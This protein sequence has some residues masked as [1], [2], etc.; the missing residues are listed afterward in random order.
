[1]RTELLLNHT[2]SFTDACVG[3]SESETADCRC[4]WNLWA[5][6]LLK[7]DGNKIKR[8]LLFSYLQSVTAESQMRCWWWGLAQTTEERK[9][10]NTK[11]IT[12]VVSEHLIAEKLSVTAGW[13]PLV[14]KSDL[15][16]RFLVHIKV[17][18]IWLIY[19]CGDAS[20]IST[21]C[22]SSIR[23]RLSDGGWCYRRLPPHRAPSK[24]ETPLDFTCSE[25]QLSHHLKQIRFE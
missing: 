20:L 11:I 4:V 7:M 1:M 23:W 10:K 25:F 5:S 21:L 15:A 3:G 9:S 17:A 12:T 24:T 22:I 13:L 2:C 19:D 6:D 16:C 8:R 18:Y 14:N